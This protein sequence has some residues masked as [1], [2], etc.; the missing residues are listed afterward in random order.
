MEKK[1]TP[2]PG[3][4]VFQKKKNQMN[5]VGQRMGILEVPV[6]PLLINEEGETFFT[7]ENGMTVKVDPSAGHKVKKAS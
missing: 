3:W 5:S 6:G 2:V 1:Y 4:S 7:N